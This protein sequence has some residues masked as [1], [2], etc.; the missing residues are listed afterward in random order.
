MQIQKWST[1][2]GDY[3]EDRLND[4]PYEIVKRNRKMKRIALNILYSLFTAGIL[5]LVLLLTSG[6]GG[7]GH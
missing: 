6:I 4:D 7:R 2:S 5:I 3:T 1:L